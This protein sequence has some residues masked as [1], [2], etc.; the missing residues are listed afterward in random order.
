MLYLTER[1]TFKMSSFGFAKG[2]YHI[3]EGVV[4][5]VDITTSSITMSENL[6]MGNNQIDN[7]A[8]P[9]AALDAVN[10][11][12][13]QANAAI[14]STI[15]LTGTAWTSISSETIGSFTV[16]V[17]PIISGG[18]SGIFH[19]TKN[20]ATK[21]SGHIVRLARMR[22]D[23]SNE[24]LLLRW[25]TSSGIELSKNGTSHDGDYRVKIV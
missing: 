8:D 25:Q 22:G 2:T 17:T 12:Y 18:A 24:S 21:T 9:T 19:I 20:V 11:Q 15:T 10:L 4:Q 16:Y 23:T 13:L 14:V 1:E 3:T 5:N 6:D 7:V